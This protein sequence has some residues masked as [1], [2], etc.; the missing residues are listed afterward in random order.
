M[1]K[2]VKSLKNSCSDGETT[3][4]F[5]FEGR[6]DN[7]YNFRLDPNR[8]EDSVLNSKTELYYITMFVDSEILAGSLYQ[9]VFIQ[10]EIDYEFESVS[11][12]DLR[13]SPSKF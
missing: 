1:K 3:G 4:N 13:I 5:I 7:H 10:A 8:S 6:E 12:T 2:N 9:G 11:S